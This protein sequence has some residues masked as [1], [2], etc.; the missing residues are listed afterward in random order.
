MRDS[1][2]KSEKTST[3]NGQQGILVFTFQKGTFVFATEDRISALATS[4]FIVFLLLFFDSLNELVELFLLLFQ[5]FQRDFGPA[6]GA[7]VLLLH[8]SG[9]AC[10]V[11]IMGFARQDDHLHVGVWVAPNLTVNT[12]LLLAEVFHADAARHVDT[13]LVEFSLFELACFCR[14]EIRH[15]LTQEGFLVLLLHFG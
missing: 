4:P 7:G 13:V 8:P 12:A 2:N 15:W 6:H 11:E 14:V 5:T 1:I 9:D 10:V 3:V